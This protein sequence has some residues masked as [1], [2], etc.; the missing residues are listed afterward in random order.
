MN[1]KFTP[2]LVLSRQFYWEIVRPIFDTQF[3]QVPHSAALLGSGSEVLGFDTALSMDH[4]WGPRVLLFLEEEQYP[5]LFQLI[6]SAILRALPDVYHGYAIDPPSKTHPF[7]SVAVLTMRQFVLDHLG[8]DIQTELQPADWLTFPEQELSGVTKGAIHWDGVNI[9]AVRKR[10]AYYPR[11]IWLYLMAAGWNRIG[12]EEHFIG[13]TG[14][15]GDEI[16][17]AIIAARLVRDIIRLCF[18]IEKQYS[19][20]SKWLGTAFARLAVATEL[21]PALQKVLSAVDWQERQKYLSIAYETLANRHNRLGITRPME[22][23]VSN[24]YDRPFLVIHGEE[25]AQAIREH[26]SD[27]A[28]REIADKPLIGSIDQYSDS[29]DLVGC[30]RIREVLKQLYQL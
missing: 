22:V 18:L 12:Q 4:D 14:V 17:S 26:I 29:T 2:G 21:A 8:Y 20:Y 13:R 23:K 25:F 3:P 24:F 10:F 1:T 9:E 16:G 5:H 27:P 15:V 28:V 19:P 30:V 7:Q 6:S 11:D